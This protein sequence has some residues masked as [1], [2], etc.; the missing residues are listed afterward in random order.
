MLTTIAEI[1]TYFTLGINKGNAGTVTPAEFDVL[2]NGAAMDFVQYRA[3]MAEKDQRVLDDLRAL[4]P[5]PLVVANTGGTTPQTEEFLLPYTGT[6]AAGTTH[7][8]LHMLS[9]A[10][11]VYDQSEP[12]IPAPCR[13]AD[14]W[15]AGRIMRRDYRYD[16]QRNPFKRGQPYRPLYWM[17]EGAVHVDCGTGFHAQQARME[18]IRYPV[19]VSVQN[20]IDPDLPPAVNQQIA[21]FAVRRHLENIESRRYG[22]YTEER[23][24]NDQ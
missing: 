12:P 8:Y 23:R 9:V 5:P 16:A 2:Y 19:E 4:V 24:I 22:T 14:D 11:R 17:S 13:S 15:A 1:Y 6:P 20:A 21:D 10:F 7:G 3:R 18:Y